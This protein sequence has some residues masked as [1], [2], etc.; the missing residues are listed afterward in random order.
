MIL[1]TQLIYITQARKKLSMNLK[2]LQYQPSQNIMAN[3]YSG[4]G[5]QIAVL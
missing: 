1:I 3:F 2:T 5:Q 4:S